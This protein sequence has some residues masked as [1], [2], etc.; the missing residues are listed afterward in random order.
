M[1]ILIH[2]HSAQGLQHLVT[3]ATEPWIIHTYGLMADA[4]SLP[5]AGITRKFILNGLQ[6]C[7]RVLDAAQHTTAQHANT[8]LGSKGALEPALAPELAASQQLAAA[9]KS[10]KSSTPQCEVGLMPSHFEYFC[11][12]NAQLG[13]HEAY[14]QATADTQILLPAAAAA[15]AAVA[16]TGATESAAI[17]AASGEISC[18]S[19]ASN[20]M[21]EAMLA[22]ALTSGD[23]SG[24]DSGSGSGSACGSVRVPIAAGELIS[25]EFSYKYSQEEVEPLAAGAGSVVVREWSDAQQ[26]YG[27]H[28][29]QRC[30]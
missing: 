13:R 9:S 25:F 1:T 28:L 8:S 6:H 29:L 22:A 27:L 10:S 11:C 26:Q 7:R 21:D 2:C 14:Y 4:M 30:A 23:S 19:S 20:R 15:A 18:S 12:Y 3:V 5:V 24:S 17:G 16:V